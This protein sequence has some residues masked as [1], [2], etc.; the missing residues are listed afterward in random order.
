LTDLLAASNPERS[1]SIG[2]V[3]VEHSR[4]LVKPLPEGTSAFAIE[5]IIGKFS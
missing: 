2:V 4:K 3:F 1:F 5:D